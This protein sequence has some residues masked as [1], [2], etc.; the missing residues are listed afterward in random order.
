MIRRRS[1]R[2]K[3][4]CGLLAS[5]GSLALLVGCLEYDPALAGPL[6]A[7]LIANPDSHYPSGGLGL[8]TS[9]GQVAR[10]DVVQ[11]CRHT[12]QAVTANAK[13]Y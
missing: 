7:Q 4:H 1:P 3:Q 6:H 10:G 2:L 8:V 11:A 5:V 9:P 12:D 13:L